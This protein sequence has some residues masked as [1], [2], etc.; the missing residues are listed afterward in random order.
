[1][2]L[3]SEV[4]NLRQP[5]RG[6]TAACLLF[7]LPACRWGAKP[8]AAAGGASRNRCRCRL[9]LLL[10]LLLLEGDAHHCWMCLLASSRFRSSSAH[11]GE[12]RECASG[13]VSSRRELSA[14]W[15]Q[16][17]LTRTASRTC[18]SR[19][20]QGKPNPGKTNTHTHT[21]TAAAACR[22]R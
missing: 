17:Q 12:R 1:M 21:H 10:L 8:A 2:P 9:L 16:S 6:S 13:H 7:L 11:I 22:C 19:Y 18:L 4:Y 20:G 3:H 5:G 15:R 14:W